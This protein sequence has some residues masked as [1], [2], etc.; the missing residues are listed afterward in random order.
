MFNSQTYSSLNLYRVNIF[1]QPAPKTLP[2]PLKL[3]LHFLPVT[4]F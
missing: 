3:P 2:A 1:I 4:D